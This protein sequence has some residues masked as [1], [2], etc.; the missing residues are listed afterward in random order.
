MSVL[1]VCASVCQCVSCSDC[2]CILRTTSFILCQIRLGFSYSDRP[3]HHSGLFS[4][5][6]KKFDKH[7]GVI[8]AKVRTRVSLRS[9]S[10][11]KARDFHPQGSPRC[12]WSPIHLEDLG[13]V[14]AAVIAADPA[15][16]KGQAFNVCGDDAVDNGMVAAAVANVRV[17][18]CCIQPFMPVCHECRE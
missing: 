6:F 2:H 11:G 12:A 15:A 17:L 10:C 9:C 3:Q 4:G 18:R 7:A 1:T 5:V 16:V 8:Q 14:Y 13:P